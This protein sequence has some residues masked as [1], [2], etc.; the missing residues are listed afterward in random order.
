[1][2][3]P[4]DPS[5]SPR[6]SSASRRDPPLSPPYVRVKAH[7]RGQGSGVRRRGSEFRV[8][9]SRKAIAGYRVTV[10]Y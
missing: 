5:R 8:W 10:E 4:P 3:R 2:P 6:K 7:V 9:D 1:M